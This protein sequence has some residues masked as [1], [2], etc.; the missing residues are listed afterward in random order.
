MPVTYYTSDEYLSLLNKYTEALDKVNVLEK[1]RPLWAHGFSSDS[2]AAVSWMNA[3]SNMWDILG[4]DN[5]TDA[6]MKLRKLVSK[7]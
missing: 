1:L 7:S 6:M 2:V 4:A 5:Q 3:A